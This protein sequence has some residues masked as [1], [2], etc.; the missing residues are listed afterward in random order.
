MDGG[1]TCGG[2]GPSRVASRT[3]AHGTAG[4]GGRSR[5]APIG[6]AAYGTPRKVC[7]P[8]ANAAP[9]FPVEPS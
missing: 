5:F 8:S 3:P 4:C 1:A 6:G 7:T 2:S 9:Q